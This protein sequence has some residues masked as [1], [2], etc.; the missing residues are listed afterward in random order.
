MTDAVAVPAAVADADKRCGFIAIIGAPNAGKSTLVNALVGTKIT[1]VSRKVQT[2]RVPIR[3]IALEGASQ[4]VFVD[5]PGL[6]APKRR[7]DRAMVEAAAAVAGDADVVAFLVDVTR[8]I[9]EDVE[10]IVDGLGKIK[11]PVVLVLNKV[12][13][14]KKDKL[15]PLAAELNQRHR[16]AETFMISALKSKGLKELRAFLAR[17]VPAGP[18]HY[19]EDEITDANERLTAAEITRE[20]IYAYLHEELPY[21]ATDRKSVV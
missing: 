19:P 21:A 3:G 6:F 13:D 15:L 18:W 14:I 2:T 17:H 7:L 4:L 9:T 12:D 5:T 11:S 16:F 20:K 8:G 1:I 10:R